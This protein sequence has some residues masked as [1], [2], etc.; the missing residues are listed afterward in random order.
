MMRDLAPF[1]R[2]LTEH[3]GSPA[4]AM[5]L[6]EALAEKG[7]KAF[8]D[9]DDAVVQLIR[10]RAKQYSLVDPSGAPVRAR[11]A[12]LVLVAAINLDLAD[13]KTSQT[14]ERRL[15]FTEPNGRVEDRDRIDL[16]LADVIRHS[17]TDLHIGSAFWNQ[18]GIQ[19]LQEVL[20]PA[21]NLR[22]VGAVIYA[23]RR[24]SEDLLELL[25]P[26]RGAGRQRLS[27]LWYE[28]PQ[29]SLMHAKFIVADRRRGYLGTAN[30]TSQGMRHHIE[31]GVE[32]SEAQASQLVTFL[33]RLTAEGVF[34][35]DENWQADVP[36]AQ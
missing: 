22:G 11:M 30:L 24:D 9:R 33:E 23:Q 14:S 36:Q 20:D 7:L 35:T 26:L 29:Q 34:T 4:G 2:L 18:S 17:T 12:E 3:T 32:L 25:G 5:L 1:V 13:P 28:G 27:V 6:V 16:Y 10:A 19:Y 21:I 8:E 31:V 15:L